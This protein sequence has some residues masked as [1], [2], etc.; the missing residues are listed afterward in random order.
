MVVL[1]D[2]WYTQLDRVRAAKVPFTVSLGGT[3]LV[4]EGITKVKQVIR[5]KIKPFS[6]S[7][8]TRLMSF[9]CKSKRISRV[10]RIVRSYVSNG[11]EKVNN[12]GDDDVVDD[13][14]DDDDDER[15]R[16]R[17]EEVRMRGRMKVSAL[18]ITI[19]KAQQPQGEE[20]VKL[21]RC[22]MS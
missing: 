6:W 12:D 4:D 11:K 8:C 10:K 1:S 3:F 19:A 21:I 13:D 18:V 9:L 22:I 14:D 15:R 20:T 17:R 16:S 5:S 2:F 7:G